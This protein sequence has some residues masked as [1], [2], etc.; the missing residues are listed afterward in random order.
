M[1]LQLEKYSFLRNNKYYKFLR[2]IIIPFGFKLLSK[3]FSNKID[4]KLIIMGGYGG[5]L[6]HDNTKYLFEYLNQHSD[7]KVVWVAKSRKLVKEL[8]L[9]GY[10]AI[11]TLNIMA[12]KLLRK[13][14]FIFITHGIY[15]VLPI[16][17]SPRSTTILTWHG[18]PIKKIIFDEDLE[19][20]VYK[21]WGRYFKLKLKYN[22]YLNYILTPTRDDLEH[23]ILSSAFKV[24]KEKILALGYP[25]NDILF[26]K[27]EN[28]IENLKTKYQIPESVNQII[29][30]C[31]TF[32]EDHSLKFSISKKELHELNKMLKDMK[33]LFLLKGHY[34]VQ[35]VNFKE[36]ENL[37]LVPKSA[38]IQELYI[39]T[40]I[41]ITDYS[42]T[43]LDFSLLNRPILLF[44]YDL[45]RYKKIRGMYY[46]LEDIAP[47]PLLY[48]FKDLT[49][50]IKNIENITKEFEQKRKQVRDR[51]N[52]Y[53]DGNSIRRILD[54]LEI[55]Y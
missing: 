26:N 17:F 7:Y 43:M 10:N 36:Y 9:K 5:N 20:L 29:L 48:N 23:N 50:A 24:P 42:S 54:F 13:A 49:N 51:F 4:E 30:Y 52:R 34:F 22:D 38:D 25:R 53:T 33:T 16:E 3:L 11:H 44:P 19:F 21:K 39:I 14:R 37:K 45:E 46:K 18:T 1:V 40:D 35:D 47:G 8:R 27:D 15:D 12:I 2:D 32:R 55:E 31:P 28:F 41:L 6:Y